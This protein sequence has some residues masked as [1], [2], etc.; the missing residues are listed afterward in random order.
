MP[1]DG[2]SSSRNTTS[3]SHNGGESHGKGTNTGLANGS[4]TLAKSKRSKGKG[5]G[6]ATP[7]LLDEKELPATFEESSFEDNVDFIAFEPEPHERDGKGEQEEPRVE[8][9]DRDAMKS[10]ERDGGDSK[11]RK[12]DFD[13]N[14]GYHNKRERTNAA[15]RKAP[16]VAQ[17]DWEGSTNVA[18]LCVFSPSRCIMTDGMA[19]RLHREVVAFVKYVSP[20]REED[21]VRSL[22]V[23]LI[24]Q[25]ITGKF[26][27]AKVLAFG[28]Y[29]TK[30]YLPL[31][32]VTDTAH[33]TSFNL[34]ALK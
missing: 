13:Q 9:R 10:R 17:V 18:E 34:T 19:Y 32:Y 25:A 26:P 12:L 27:D 6:T 23:T 31:G 3:T 16:W 11:K 29:E 33:Q 28:S 15:S 22:V 24:S 1:L 5:S 7:A 21:E 14:D 8:E 30:L 4:T 20:T 2:P